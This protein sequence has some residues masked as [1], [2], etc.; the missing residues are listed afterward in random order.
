MKREPL[1]GAQ[2]RAPHLPLLVSFFA[3]FAARIGSSGRVVPLRRAERVHSSI[4]QRVSPSVPT[5]HQR[6]ARRAARL[7]ASPCPRKR[8][9]LEPRF[10]VASWHVDRPRLNSIAIE[11]TAHCNQKCAYCY[12]EWREDGGAAVGAPRGATLFARVERLLDAIEVDHVILTGG[13]P[14][15]HKEVF[16]L[17]ERLAARGVPAQ[18]ISNGGLV[19]D[20]IAARL[21]ALRLR[22]VQV[23]LNGPDATLHEAHVGPGCFEPTLAGIRA[24]Q[25]HKVPVIGSVVVTRK[26]AAKTGETLAL[27]RDLG[28]RLVALSRF[29]PAGYA[30]RHAAELLCGVPELTLAFEQALP[31]ARDLGMDLVVTMPVPPCAVEVE[32]FAP[33]RFGACPI[34]TSAQEIALGP[35]GRLRNCT[36]HGGAIGGGPDL[37]DPAVDIAAL[38]RAPEVTEYRKR[39]PAFCEG[40]MHAETCGGGCGAAA[41]WMLGDA[42]GFPDPFVWQHIDDDFA[43]RLAAER[44]RP[45]DG[46]RRL[47]V[48]S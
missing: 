3:A 23:T 32:R 11:L 39:L 46:R 21:A 30:A 7:S 13:E 19:D 48:L 24:L 4:H 16:S 37:L 29:S 12:N 17:L 15:A 2:E 33:I 14:L 1:L 34:G 45:S 43:A 35:D 9:C 44:A 27:W 6:V 18:M 31:F 5:P 20:R 41:A 25:R 47:E 40:C 8:G 26:N 38:L 28:V 22:S 36:L 10:T 42:R